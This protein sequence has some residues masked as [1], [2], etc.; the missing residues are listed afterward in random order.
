[1]TYLADFIVDEGK[2]F[3]HPSPYCVKLMIITGIIWYTEGWWDAGEHDHNTEACLKELE[4]LEKEPLG[5]LSRAVLACHLENV[6]D[7][8]TRLKAIMKRIISVTDDKEQHIT[9]EGEEMSFAW[10]C[11]DPMCA[12]LVAISLSIGHTEIQNSVRLLLQ[13]QLAVNINHGLWYCVGIALLAV[14]QSKANPESRLAIIC[15]GELLAMVLSD[16][17]AAPVRKAFQEE[18][19]RSTPDETTLLEVLRCS[20]PTALAFTKEETGRRLSIVSPGIEIISWALPVYHRKLLLSLLLVF[21]TYPG[22]SCIAQTVANLS[23]MCGGDD[24]ARTPATLL[25]EVY[26]THAGDKF[27]GLAL[28]AAADLQSHKGVTAATTV[29]GAAQDAEAGDEFDLAA[30]SLAALCCGSEATWSGA[31]KSFFVDSAAAPM[32]SPTAM[33]SKSFIQ[34]I[35]NCCYVAMCPIP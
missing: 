30:L 17:D 21:L 3:M 33:A 16:D 26:N 20:G 2:A 27:V 10:Y 29:L 31:L 7:K 12:A 22:V 28:L 8:L 25:D 35:L 23:L 19:L 18:W 11:L 14:S 5:C 24:D 13:H 15:C 4:H 9:E 32:S 6:H 34:G 1:M